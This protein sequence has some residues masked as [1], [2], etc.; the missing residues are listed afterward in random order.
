MNYIYDIILNF[1]QE[2]YPFYE[3]KKSDNIINIRKIPCFKVKDQDYLDLK[4]NQITI[5]EDFINKINNASSIYLEDNLHNNICLVTN[6][7]EAMGLSFDEKGNLQK[8]SSTI[9]D[10]E[11]EIIEESHHQ[12]ITNL[13][14]IKNNPIKPQYIGRIEKEKRTYLNKYLSK[15]NET[16]DNVT[17]KYLYYEYFEKENEDS[18]Y[19][20][21]ALLNTLKQEW[22][23]KLDR[24][25]QLVLLLNKVH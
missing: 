7:K 12:K 15:L 21:K 17:I 22:N 4:H 5:Q 8:R 11:Q 1:N 18:H 10:E 20:K 6:G 23:N 9:F 24:L 3:W 13:K 25:Y 16:T 14:F 2:Y 19:T